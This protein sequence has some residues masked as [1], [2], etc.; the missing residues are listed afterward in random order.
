MSMGRFD[1]PINS[2]PGRK[3]PTTT[4]ITGVN[5]GYDVD[6]RRFVREGGVA[7]GRLKGVAGGKLYFNDDVE[8][9]LTEA[10]RAFCDFKRAADECASAK[11][12]DL[13]VEE[14]KD[15]PGR[16]VPVL[17]IPNLDLKTANIGS[18][19]WCTGFSSPACSLALVKTLRTLPITW[20][21]PGN[22]TGT[23]PGCAQHCEIIRVSKRERATRLFVDGSRFGPRGLGW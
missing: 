20:P 17:P 12:L 16:P 23:A 7:L 4:V 11:S 1:V 8:D 15:T 13:P 9:V 21:K 5:G 2:F 10:D 22:S 3:Y 18:V 19:V 14:V 6:V